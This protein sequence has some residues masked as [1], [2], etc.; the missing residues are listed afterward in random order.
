MLIPRRPLVLVTAVVVIAALVLVP[1]L[2]L[3][4]AFDG[5]ERGSGTIETEP[6]ALA[7]WRETVVPVFGD[8]DSVPRLRG[9]T[10]AGRTTLHGCG[11]D[12]S[13]G[14][15]YGI[16][17]GRFWQGPGQDDGE[18]HPSISTENVANF[19]TVVVH[20]ESRGWQV[21]DTERQW[22]PNAPDVEYARRAELE[23]MV[24]GTRVQA[25]VQA[26]LADSLHVGLSFEGA[27]PGCATTTG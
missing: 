3:L 21:T 1:A 13:S 2:G 11:T 10:P 24:A 27:P 8:L 14:V 7:A 4:T 20:L 26:H 9:L 23:R 15:V 19:E 16:S 25:G 6:A 22:D 17:A 12:E 18:P 5:P